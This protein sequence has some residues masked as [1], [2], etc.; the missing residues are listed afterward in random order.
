MVAVG[1]LGIL[2]TGTSAI[3]IP[4]KKLHFLLR[5]I[6]IIQMITL[7]E[8]QKVLTK[9]KVLM[10]LRDSAPILMNGFPHFL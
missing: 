5:N 10:I 4:P 6:F 2:R 1:T 7:V 3:P 9:G 8:N